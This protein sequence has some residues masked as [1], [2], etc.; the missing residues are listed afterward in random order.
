MSGTDTDA[1]VGY[2]IR[3][4]VAHVGL[5]RP[6]RH[7]SLVP[8]LL[9]GLLEALMRAESDPRVQAVLLFGQGPSFSTGGDLRAFLANWD[10]VQDYALELVGLLN[11][12][13]LAIL[14]LGKPV[15][16]ALHGFTTGGSLGFAFA[17]DVALAASDARFGAFYGR[18][19]FSPDGGCTMLL[20]NLVGSGRARTFLLLDRPLSAEEALHWGLVTE[21]V[22]PGGLL[23]RA[24]AV[25][26]QVARLSPESLRRA[27]GLLNADIDAV[28]A[29]LERE[30]QEF[31]RNLAARGVRSSIERYLEEMRRKR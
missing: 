4:C 13:I 30:R 9:Q 11:E 8:A 18:V 22:P 16:A 14:R 5:S 1:L 6:Q 20:P 19:G 17:S 7:N 23:E 31:V 28:E 12:A 26:A 15:V 27:K 29:G 25:A 10:H 3:D 2:T 21:L 24:A